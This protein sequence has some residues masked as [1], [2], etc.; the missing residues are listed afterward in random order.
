MNSWSITKRSLLKSVSS[1]LLNKYL[2]NNTNSYQALDFT[3]YHVQM[4]LPINFQMGQV[5][6]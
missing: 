5:F 3:S 1:F 4:P 2:E 6:Y